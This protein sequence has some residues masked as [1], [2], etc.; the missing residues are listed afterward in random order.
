MN[1]DVTSIRWP[2]NMALVSARE[3]ILRLLGTAHRPLRWVEMTNALGQFSSDARVACEWLMNHGYIAPLR[4]ADGAVR[5]V[6]VGWTLADK[7][8]VWARAHGALLTA[9]AMG[10]S[11]VPG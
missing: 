3:L 2:D 6:E 4:V 1:S 10:A 11:G 8:L 7:G 9:R 5:S